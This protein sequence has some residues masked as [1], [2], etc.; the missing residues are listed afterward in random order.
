MQAQV[1]AEQR[2]RQVESELAALAAA[3]VQQ[4]KD[5]LAQHRL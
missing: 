3:R 4:R 5:M 2:R 1:H